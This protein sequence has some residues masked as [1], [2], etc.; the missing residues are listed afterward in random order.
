M[1]Q[2]CK[3]ALVA[4]TIVWLTA[5]AI[6]PEA[7]RNTQ[8]AAS[9]ASATYTIVLIKIAHRVPL[10]MPFC[11][12]LR[13]PEMLTPAK[14]PVAAGKKTANTE[15]KFSPSRY[16]GPKFSLNRVRFNPTKP[17]ALLSSLRGPMPVPTMTSTME[18]TKMQR[19]N[20]WVRTTHS[21]PIRVTP[22]NNNTVPIPTMRIML[23]SPIISTPLPCSLIRSLTVSAKPTTYNATATALATEKINPMEPPNSGPRLR[24]IK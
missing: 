9:Q 11:A 20:I 3:G 2:S 17:L 22:S 7:S 13:S 15:K 23:S 14:M 8:A 21:K 5:T 6:T 19:R 16:A 24:D 10:G 1:V 12:S 18:T 4:F